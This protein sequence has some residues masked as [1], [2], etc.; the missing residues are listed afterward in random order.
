MIWEKKQ[1]SVRLPLEMVFFQIAVN[2]LVTFCIA[3]SFE[4]MF[5]TTIKSSCTIKSIDWILLEIS[6]VQ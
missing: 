3:Y 1:V 4:T 5:C 2:I 6:L